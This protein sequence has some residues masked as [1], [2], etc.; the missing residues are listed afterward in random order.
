MYLFLKII[1]IGVLMV[2]G[3]ISLI[4]PMLLRSSAAVQILTVEQYKRNTRIVGAVLIAIA[5][6]GL[7]KIL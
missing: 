2:T 3:T 1:S 6:A 5:I 4:K 7:F